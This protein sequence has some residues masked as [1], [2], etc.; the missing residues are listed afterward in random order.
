MPESTYEPKFL[1]FVLDPFEA[2]SSIQITDKKKK[3]KALEEIT[4]Y[5]QEQ[6]LSFI[7][8]GKS[9][10]SGES[11]KKLSS[12]YA[13][14]M[15]HGDSTPNLDLY[16]DM[17]DALSVKEDKGVISLQIEG[18]QAEKADG[19]CK[20]TGRENDIPRRRFIPGEGQTFRK[21]IMTGIKNIISDYAD[22]NSIEFDQ[23]LFKD[24]KRQSSIDDAYNQDPTSNIRI[25]GDGESGAV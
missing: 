18:D 16:G 24:G 3:A 9:P 2:T 12:A 15:K 25:T 8:E 10:V 19:H 23:T 6:V 22:D 17:L 20:L 14:K 5:V 11:F 7:G 4:S 13:K 1:S 21:E